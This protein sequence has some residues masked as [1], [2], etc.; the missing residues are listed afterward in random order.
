MRMMATLVGINPHRFLYMPSL[1]T[2]I[3]CCQLWKACRRFWA[4]EAGWAPLDEQTVRHDDSEGVSPEEAIPHQTFDPSLPSIASSAKHAMKQFTFTVEDYSTI[5]NYN[6]YKT[7]NNRVKSFMKAT[8]DRPH[9]LSQRAYVF[10]H[11]CS[12]SGILHSHLH[13]ISQLVPEGCM[14]CSCPKTP[15]AR[16]P[17]G[18]SVSKGW[19]LYDGGTQ[20]RLSRYLFLNCLSHAFPKDLLVLYASFLDQRPWTLQ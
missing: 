14:R 16:Q 10:T 20:S 6:K 15:Q 3:Q 19:P 12:C 9:M 1:Q 11:R 2:T 13:M 8:R 17:F 7:C 4:T 5:E 18:V